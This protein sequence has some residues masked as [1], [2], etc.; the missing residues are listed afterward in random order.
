MR[1]LGEILG[2]TRTSGSSA[3]PGPSP[4]ARLEGGAATAAAEERCLLCDGARFVR[5]TADPA[6]PDF[7][8]P[9]PCA[10]A[11][12][13]D[14]RARRERLLRYSRLGALARFTFD[15]LLRTG[16]TSDTMGRERYSAAVEAAERY[17]EQPEGWLVLTGAPG[18]GK[19]HIAAA[20]ATRAIEQGRPA[21]FLT[22]A[23]LLD[24]L[25]AGYGDD[26]ELG[27]DELLAEVRGA[28]LLVLDDLDSFS[29][30]PWAREKFFQVVSHRFNAL[31][32]TVFTC[33]RP[34]AEIDAR[35]GARLTD[36][37]ISQ[38][39]DLAEPS[40]PRY[41]AVGGMAAER[42]AEF[43]FES[44][45]P[46]GHGLRGESRRNLEGAF[47][48]AHHWAESPDGWLVLQ[49]GPGCGKTHLAAAIANHRLA[50]GDGVCFAS[51][52]DLLDELRASYAP[53]AGERFDALFRRL[54]D[55]RLLVLD[56]LGAHHSSPWA[57]EKL[58]QL[59]NHRYLGRM[60]TVV[61]RNSDPSGAGGATEGARG[62]GRGRRSAAADR[63]GGDLEP[64]I[65]S[66]L[67]DL[68]VATNY[69]I[70]A[71]DYRVG[72]VG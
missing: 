51:V 59:L 72:D 33:V 65:R 10:C 46:G 34:P 54:L 48:L 56:D 63:A 37:Q 23:D 15:T 43:T 6:H 22:V 1:A 40:A 13:E 53:D 29:G 44:F 57:E 45:R 55:V 70:V 8:Q 31:A 5:V 71:P 14:E 62:R 36:P 4:E 30:T 66:R 60:A 9:V 52:P 12:R 38:I 68:Q 3:V 69:E 47:R 7:G 39:W 17:A 2:A 27:Y 18:C 35:L 11:A 61:T 20:I 28:P 67:A 41:V 24:R 32:P 21:L 26:A 16:R 42:L 50:A 25:R 58:Y 19:T 64:R 49:G